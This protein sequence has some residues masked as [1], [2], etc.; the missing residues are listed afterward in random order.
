[1]NWDDV[2]YLL[3]LHRGGS[4]TAAAATLGVNHA[5]VSR[6]IAR[7]ETE[8]GQSVFVKGPDRFLLTSFGESLLPGALQ[9][10]TAFSGFDRAVRNADQAPSGRVRVASSHLMSRLLLIPVVRELRT[11]HPG[12]VVEV[13]EG[14]RFVDLNGDDFDDLVV[15]NGFLTGP[16]ED[17]L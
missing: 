6:R 16:I 17:D 4:L 15:P 2:R 13:V 12:I 10:E 8:V 9:I 5:T 7:L 1:M 14:A 3:A 11:E